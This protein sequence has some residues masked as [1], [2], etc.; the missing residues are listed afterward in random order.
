VRHYEIDAQTF[1]RDL[2]HRLKCF[3][4]VVPPLRRRPGDIVLLIDYFMS[5]LNHYRGCRKLFDGF[6]VACLLKYDWPGNVRELRSV[7]EFA[8]HKATGNTITVEDLPSD[9]LTATALPDPGGAFTSCAPHDAPRPTQ[10]PSEPPTDFW[11]DLHRP[12]MKRDLNR[13]QVRTI[14]TRC[15][16]RSAGSYR[17]C[18]LGLGVGSEE[19]LRAMDFLRFHDLKPHS[20]RRAMRHGTLPP[21]TSLHVG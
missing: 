3:C 7:T 16:E 5:C 10:P 12:F 14:L 1:R 6:A 18:L 17:A 2:Y 19:Y 4:V 20:Y 21:P 11:R 9:V 13:E 8:F 15:L